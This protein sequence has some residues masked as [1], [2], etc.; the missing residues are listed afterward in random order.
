MSRLHPSSTR[1]IL[2]VPALA[3]AG[4]YTPTAGVRVPLP[5]PLSPV[6]G[7]APTLVEGLSLSGFFGDGFWGQEQERAE[8]L[9]FGAGLSA[10][11]RVEF[12]ASAFHSTR[13]VPGP[14]D[15]DLNGPAVNVL[16]FKARLIDLGSDRLT[17]GVR[18]GWFETDRTQSDANGGEAQNDRL[19]VWDV[20]VPIEVRALGAD[21]FLGHVAAY[22]APR[23]I[24]QTFHSFGDRDR[25]TA[26][27]LALGFKTTGAR[28][29]VVTEATL[30][31]TPEIDVGGYRSDPGWM[32][33]P[34]ITA[35]IYLGAVER[36]SR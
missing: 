35:K 32:L 15:A 2:V 34:S 28:L 7:A 10:A 16:A 9:G 17:A 18:V 26:K 24:R 13:S 21:G 36:S 19:S 20:S 31:R 8:L 5:V 12:T 3:S 33:V 1:W 6:E 4:C 14:A 27:G 25:G 22:V 11:D 23:V 30:I 29:G